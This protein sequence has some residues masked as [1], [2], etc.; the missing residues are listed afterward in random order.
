MNKIE[1]SNCGADTRIE[2]GS[3]KF[4][5][6]GLSVVLLGIDVVHC[7]K[8]ANEDPMIP[9][10][11]DLMRLLAAIVVAKRARLSGPEIRFLRKYL[12]MSGVWTIEEV[13]TTLL[14]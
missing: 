10:I 11:N 3:Y 5:E 6:S 13:I 7:D 8:C 12:R 2:R 14:D 9:H 4:K 1:C